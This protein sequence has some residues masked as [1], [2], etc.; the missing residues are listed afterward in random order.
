V[1]KTLKEKVKKKTLVI[2]GIVIT[3]FLPYMFSLALDL[4]SLLTSKGISFLSLRFFSTL[5]FSIGFFGCI[6]FNRNKTRKNS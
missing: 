3:V 1:Y 4:S 6:N 5:K 2:L